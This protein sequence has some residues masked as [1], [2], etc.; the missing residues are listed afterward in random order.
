MNVVRVTKR[1]L[2]IARESNNAHEYFDKVSRHD[3]AIRIV[4]KDPGCL[5]QIDRYTQFHNRANLIVRYTKPNQSPHSGPMAGAQSCAIHPVRP[6]PT[7]LMRLDP[8][9]YVRAVPNQLISRE[10]EAHTRWCN[11]SSYSAPNR[12]REFRELQFTTLFTRNGA[13]HQECHS[14][15]SHVLCGILSKRPCCVAARQSSLKTF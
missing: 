2:S 7:T 8:E 13:F 14:K 9:R 5:V 11:R 12:T 3:S 6:R 10:T 15:Q 1:Q 4:H